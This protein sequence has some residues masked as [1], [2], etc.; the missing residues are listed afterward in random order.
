MVK[1]ID[2]YQIYFKDEQKPYMFDWATPYFNGNITPFFENSIISELV[3]KSDA[4][5]IAVC[6]WALRHKMRSRIPPRRELTEEVLQEDYDVMSF[7]KNSPSHDMLGALEGWHEGSNAILKLIFDRLSLK[8]PKKVTFPIYQN[9]FCASIDVYQ[10]YVVKF[11]IP[12]MYLM[13][14]DQEIRDLCYKDSGYRVT[15]LGQPV[16]FTNIKKYLG[17]DYYPMHPFILERCFSLWI[18]DKNLKVIYL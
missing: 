7:T 11:L 3:M 14:F 9:H 4:D 2:F 17:I 8:M 5:R 12:A 16:D 10:E 15:I 18:E 1:E 6:S 13:E